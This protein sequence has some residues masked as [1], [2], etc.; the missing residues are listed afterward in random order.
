MIFTVIQHQEPPRPRRSIASVP[1]DLETICLKAWRRTPN[2]R[3]ADCQE[4]A[5]D[6]RRWL[7][8]EPIQA[9]RQA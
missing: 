4:L 6:L 3:Y 2:E 1:R 8:G 7:E 5:D 9:R